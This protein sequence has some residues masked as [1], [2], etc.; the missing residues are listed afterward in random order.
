MKLIT[1]CI[2]LLIHHALMRFCYVHD[3]MPGN[4]MV[5]KTDMSL[6]CLEIKI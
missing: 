5:R 3:T 4:A 2:S 6:A 1:L